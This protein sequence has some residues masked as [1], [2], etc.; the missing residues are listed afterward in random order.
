MIPRRQAGLVLAS[1]LAAGLHPA[2]AQQDA[3]RGYPNRPVQI[4]LPASPGSNPDTATRLLAK[5]LSIRMG[6]P[7]V[8]EPK[9]GAS[10]SIAMRALARAPADGYTLSVAGIGPLAINPAVYTN[11]PY[12]ATKDFAPVGLLYKSP[13]LLVVQEGAPYHSVSELVAAARARPGVLTFASPANATAGHLGG[14]YF[15]ELAGAPLTHIPFGNAA[16]ST[17]AVAGGE[18]SMVFGSQSLSWPLVKARR[19][20]VLGMS[21]EARVPEF[22]DV[23]TLAE[24]VPGFEFSEWSGVIVPAGTP[25]AIVQRLHRE[26]AAVM[27]MPEV[28]AQ[29]RSQGIYPTLSATPAA[30]GS[31]IEGEATK[32]GGIARKIQLKLD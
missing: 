15:K 30:F 20:R 2:S 14:E 13:L 23:P 3:E 16:A 24:T 18:V 11:L 29:L 27:A 31:F 6:Q 22:P 28:A 1:L 25:P 7:F 26:I 8:V 17:V 5:H 19:L 32:W 9:L 21:S 4:L 12:D 10:G